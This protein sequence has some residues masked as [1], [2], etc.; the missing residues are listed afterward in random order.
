[1][2]STKQQSVFSPE[3]FKA[4]VKKKKSDKTYG[5]IECRWFLNSVTAYVKPLSVN[6]AWKGSRFKTKT[7]INYQK[8]LL[9]SLPDY[10]IPEGFLSIGFCF[11]FSNTLSDFDNPVKLFTDIL[12]K[13]YGFNDRMI[14]KA[15]IQVFIVKKG[16]EFVRFK[17]EKHVD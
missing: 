3:Q 14:R 12:Q 16:E 6:E 10:T 9:S 4:T 5:K 7:Y 8:A 13:R 1:M 17:I 11:G 15:V 2:T